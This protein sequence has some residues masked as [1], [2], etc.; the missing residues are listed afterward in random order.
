MM[1]FPSYLAGA[2]SNSDN[3]SDI[4]KALMKAKLVNYHEAFVAKGADDLD[5]L[6][7]ADE[8]EF[9]EIMKLVGM[10]SKPVHK[11]RFKK[12]LSEWKKGKAQD[13]VDAPGTSGVKISH[14]HIYWFLLVSPILDFLKMSTLIK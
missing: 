4:Y 13:L 12:T 11:L 9:E 5:Y 6:L 3:E 14:T 8:E 7:E 2:T 10:D 1:L